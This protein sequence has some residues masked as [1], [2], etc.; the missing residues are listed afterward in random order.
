MPSR[1]K[2]APRLTAE[3][4]PPDS[5]EISFWASFRKGPLPSPAE[6]KKYEVLYLGATKL[7]FGNF[8][9]QTNHRMKLEN[10]VIQGDGRRADKAQR[11]SLIITLA[12]L[13]LA[14]FLFYL[15][16][17]GFA[18]ATVITAI[19]PIVIAFITGSL[20]RK[21]ERENKQHIGLLR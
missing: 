9:S 7:L 4:T 11:N 18:I 21:K 13:L 1:R 2:K 20:S 3:G 10:M 8:V 19:A 5:Q 12:I 16:Q 14:A 15:G 17:N 6:M